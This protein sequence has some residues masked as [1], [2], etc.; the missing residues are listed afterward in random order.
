VDLATQVEQRIHN[1]A[2]VRYAFGLINSMR[3]RFAVLFLLSAVSVGCLGWGDLLAPKRYIAGE[4]F[5]KGDD[6]EDKFYLSAPKGSIAGPLRRIGW[7]QQYIIY[8]DDNKPTEWNVIAVKEHTQFTI[9]DVQR[10]QDSRFKQI[11]IG[12]AP[13]AWQ[14]AKH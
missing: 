1:L 4:Y 5:L 9:T 11:P 10:M 14:W 12:S 7:S 13:D 8:T 6:D 2:A 3:M